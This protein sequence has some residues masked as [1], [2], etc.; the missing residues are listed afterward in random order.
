MGCGVWGEERSEGVCVMGGVWG[1]ECE[2]RGVL[3]VLHG[4]WCVL[5]MYFVLY[6]ISSYVSLVLCIVY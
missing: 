4:V 2:E 5:I 1:V 6:I 3:F